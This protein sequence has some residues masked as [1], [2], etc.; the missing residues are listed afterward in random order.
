MLDGWPREDIIKHLE[1]CYAPDLSPQ[2]MAAT[3]AEACM[4]LDL[5]SPDDDITIIVYKLR[6][7]QAVNVLIGP[8]AHRED[9]E[10]V[11]RMFFSKE[12]RHIVCGGTTAQ[13]ASR[14]LRAPVVPLP[15]TGTEEIPRPLR[16]KASTL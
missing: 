9:D 6:K 4:D 1:D 5:G 11:M 12:G 13:A 2:R 16:S 3:L 14:Y 10:S 7:R 15:D 8:P